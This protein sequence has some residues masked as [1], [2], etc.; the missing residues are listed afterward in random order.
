MKIVHEIR[1]ECG[2][3]HRIV[4]HHT[5]GTQENG[6]WAGYTHIAE[7]HQYRAARKEYWEGTF[8]EGVFVCHTVGSPEI[9]EPLGP[10][11]Q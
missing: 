7:L 9:F 5:N 11:F 6:N 2:V 4:I 1:P 8:P 10:V 3:F